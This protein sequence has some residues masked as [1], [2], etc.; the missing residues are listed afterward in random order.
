MTYNRP[1][2]IRLEDGL[3]KDTMSI[4]EYR[5]ITISKLIRELLNELVRLDN[6]ENGCRNQVD[7]NGR[8]IK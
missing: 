2:H 8:Y 6:V 3:Y 7:N 5:G 1:V 4:C